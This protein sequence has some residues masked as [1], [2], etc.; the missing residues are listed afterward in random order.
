MSRIAVIS[1]MIMLFLSTAQM[2]AREDIA[3]ITFG[4][5]WSGTAAIFTAYHF[6]YFSPDGYRYNQEGTETGPTFNGESLLHMGYN[7]NDNWNL[8]IYTGFTGI[9]RIHN[10]IPL[11]FRA[12]RLFR[13]NKY[14]DR[15]L[16]FADAGTGFSL[17]KHIQEIYALKFGSGYRFSLSR[18]SK[19]DLLVAAKCTYT[20]P[21][22]Y[23]E[24]EPISLRWTNRN[25]AIVVSGSVGISVTF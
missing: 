11:S 1:I 24:H 25:D 7:V 3:R 20:H 10:A 17:K 8:G 18:D 21:E 5:E 2:H 15:W 19:I 14:G 22:I 4:A 9:S 13:S 16:A 6:N 23:F 12:T